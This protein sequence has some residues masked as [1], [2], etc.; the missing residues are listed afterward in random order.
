MLI[1]KVKSEVADINT[2]YK[3]PYITKKAKKA[4]KKEYD[5]LE[6]FIESVDSD[7]PKSDELLMRW[8]AAME[9]QNEL[10]EPYVNI[11]DNRSFNTI[12]LVTENGEA[13][14]GISNSAS[15]C[16]IFHVKWLQSDAETFLMG[17]EL[18]SLRYLNK[19]EMKMLGCIENKVESSQVIEVRVKILES[20]EKSGDVETRHI[21]IMNQ[22]DGYYSHDYIIAWSG[23][24]GIPDRYDLSQL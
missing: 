15:C 21:H 16:E 23:L 2:K 18:L 20:D 19:S 4:R 5:D 1:T 3:G 7:A 17:K 6:E 14:F 8:I 10:E 9:R 11:F 12:R 24:E 13:L 22:H